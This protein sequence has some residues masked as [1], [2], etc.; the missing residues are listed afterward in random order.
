MVERKGARRIRSLMKIRVFTRRALSGLATATTLATATAGPWSTRSIDGRREARYD[1]RTV[2]GWQQA[3]LPSPQGGPDFAGSAFLHPLRTPAGFELTRIQPGDHKHH[4]G[5]WWPWKFVSNGGTT[6]NTWEIQ[7]KQ[8]AHRAIDATESVTAAEV[9]WDL[10]NSTFVRPREGPERAVLHERSSVSI[11]H[12]H[13]AFVIDIAI[14]QT[15]ADGPVT[16]GAH[17]Y[18]GFTWRGTAAWNKDNSR[19]LTS[20]GKSRDNANGTPA[21]WALVSGSTPQG[22]ATMLILSA[23]EPPENLRVWDSK[24]EN[25]ASFIN[26]NPVQNKPLPLDDEHPQVSRRGYRIIAADRAIDAAE[27]EA[28]WQAWQRR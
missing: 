10:R 8:G 9:T 16:I 22:E 23:A 18:S 3:P 13:D 7:E 19:M 17:R 5:V 25:G 1:G 24:A 21:R 26:F 28:A 15:P 2:L 4:F 11:R 27:A 20:G 14:R 6:F 12:D